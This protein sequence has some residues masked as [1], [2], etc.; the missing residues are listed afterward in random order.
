[1]ESSL[2]AVRASTGD[3]TLRQLATR[4]LAQ[5]YFATG[6]W[7]DFRSLGGDAAPDDP[8]RVMV[9]ALGAGK[10]FD[11]T[12]P[13]APSVVPTTPDA[14]LPTL[15]VA[16]N[17][18][19]FEFILDTGAP[20]SVINADVAARAGVIPVGSAQAA[21]RN[22]VT[23]RP[24]SIERLQIGGVVASNHPVL[25]V[26]VAGLTI[27]ERPSD[28]K[29]IQGIL[30]WPLI[31]R[32][33]L[34]IDL[35][36]GRTTISRPGNA[37]DDPRNLFFFFRPFVIGRDPDGM[38]L[39]L[40]LDTG[41][42]ASFLFH[43]IGKK[44]RLGRADDARIGSAAIGGTKL[45]AEGRTLRRFVLF[46]GDHRIEMRNVPLFEGTS[47]DGMLGTDLHRDGRVRIDATNGRYEL[48]SP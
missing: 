8:F 28:N 15:D 9:D 46:V 19:P 29:T 42:D 41:T 18:E 31:R 5:H 38:P 36:G 17:G 25:I 48:I 27:P 26:P 35:S 44:T 22:G 7:D 30:G 12:I 13:P 37:G 6:R 40:M 39:H 2:L 21:V 10:K 4:L 20:F 45:D 3:S 14:G 47:M 34:E 32:L 33:D 16:V 43:R 11:I 24:A 1:M 23:G